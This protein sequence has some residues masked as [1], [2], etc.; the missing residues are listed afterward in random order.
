VFREWVFVRDFVW[1]P[2]V[3]VHLF[4]MIF[5]G[6]RLDPIRYAGLWIW[7]MTKRIVGI[8]G[9]HSLFASNYIIP[10]FLVFLGLSIFLCIKYG[11]RFLKR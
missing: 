1:I 3:E 9:D 10:I 11:K 2:P 4:D 7:E 6:E 8:M 5:S